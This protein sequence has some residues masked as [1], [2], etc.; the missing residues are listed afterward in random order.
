[1]YHMCIVQCHLLWTTPQCMV[2]FWGQKKWGNCPMVMPVPGLTVQGIFHTA[3]QA[4]LGSWHVS[5][6]EQQGS[7]NAC[8]VCIAVFAHSGEIHLFFILFFCLGD[9]CQGAESDWKFLLWSMQQLSGEM[10]Q[11]GYLSQC[12]LRVGFPQFQVI[13]IFLSVVCLVQ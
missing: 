12:Q 5:L 3:R 11:C 6:Q 9:F 13:F 7:G 1:M 4:I 8:Q 2:C 10:F